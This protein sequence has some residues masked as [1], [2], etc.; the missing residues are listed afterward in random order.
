MLSP[1]AWAGVSVLRDKIFVA[2]GFDGMNRLSTVEMYD[3]ETDR[4][5]QGAEM[6]FARAGCGAALL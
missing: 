5:E 4:W 3:P 6:N 1:R 2:G